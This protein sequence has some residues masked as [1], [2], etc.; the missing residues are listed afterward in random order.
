[1]N[2]VS[3]RSGGRL[4]AVL[5]MAAVGGVPHFGRANFPIPSGY[6]PAGIVVK[7]APFNPATLDHFIFLERPEGSVVADGAGFE[8]PRW[9]VLQES[10]LRILLA[11]F[12]GGHVRQGERPR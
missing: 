4:A 11:R 7:L 2:H 3:F 1:M 9:I 6:H 5:L 12:R 8:P 10:I